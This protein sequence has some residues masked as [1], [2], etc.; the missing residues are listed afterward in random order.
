MLTREQ[1]D[2][3]SFLSGANA[4]FIAELYAQYLD[5]PNSVD[6]SWV[7]FFQDIKDNKPN[8][9]G[10]LKGASWSPNKTKI[11]TQD[12]MAVPKP[13]NTAAF[14]TTRQE[15]VDSIR[16]LMMIRVYRVRGHLEA[17]LDPLGLMERNKY[18]EL[19]P[20]SYGFSDAD[21]DRPI[22]IDGVLGFETA[23]LREIYD[24]CRATY[25]GSIGVEFMHIQDPAQKA[26]IQTAM[27][28][29]RN[30]T[31]FTADEK[32]V[33]LQELSEAEGF[34]KFLHTKFQGTKRFGLDGGEATI[35]MMDEIIKKS[36]SFG[37]REVIFGMAHR[38][39]LNVL[40]NVL[41]KPFIN[42]MAEFKGKPMNPEDIE[43][44]GD[45]KYHL[46]SSFDRDFDG[47]TCHL[48]LTP[49][50]SH[51]ESVN[52][53]AIGK[54]R[55]KQD[56]RG[57]KNRE[58]VLGII[59]HGDA[60]IAGQGLTAET[61][62][63]SQLDG[64]KTGGTI[65]IVINNQ[66]GFTTS[67]VDSRSSPYCSDVAKMVQAPIF[68]VNGDDVEAVVHVA[69]LAAEFRHQ[70][71][72][73][74]VIDM[75]CYR[76]YGHNES[77][78]PMFT[79]PLMYKAI[80][81][82]TPTREIYVQKLIDEGVISLADADA[83]YDNF[84]RDLEDSLNA[85]EKYKPNKADWLEGTW[86]GLKSGMGQAE[87]LGS[88]ALTDKALREVMQAITTTPNGFDT[89]KKVERQLNDKQEMMKSGNGIDWATAEALAFGSL[90]AE[91]HTVRLSGQDCGR[92]T[93]S[94]RH[95]VLRDQTTGEKFVPL[96]TLGKNNAFFEVIDSPLA[97]ASVLGFDYGY[98]SASPM[99][100]VLWEAQFGDFANGAQVIIDQY[101][102]SAE[103]KWLRMSGLVMLL[104]H[105]YE[106]QG[107]EH[108]SARLERFLQLCAEDNLQVANCSTPANYFHILR[109]QVKRDFRKPLIL[110]TPK[111][112][113][114]HKLCVSDMKDFAEGTTFHR[115]LPD[116]TKLAADK[117]VRR[118]VLCSGKVY[119]DLFEAREA[120]KVD[121][122]AIVRI[123]QFYPF[124]HNSLKQAIG[125]YS[126]AD[127]VW[128]QEEPENMGAWTFL[129]RR[130]EGVLKEL[131]L[132]SQRPEYVG[133]KASASPATGYLKRHLAEQENLVKTALGIN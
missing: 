126:N 48:S 27:E 37:I 34:E 54:V 61:F 69:R 33:I 66:I 89:N 72:S 97:E 3:S 105:G 13:A 109:R 47:V 67:P 23:T 17:N 113:L 90:L 43:Y 49:N 42:I 77:D 50:P 129:D 52:P 21:W 1:F 65:H 125:N 128:C 73:D 53:V 104:P 79:Q 10:E 122:V 32:K 46:G 92:G 25:C 118:V 15:T 74:I 119:Y 111:S 45:V 94:Q 24:T 57:D 5:N 86:K 101:I 82:R 44:S 131:Q 30:K 63:L 120:A 51:L 107:P 6:A 116:T 60:A 29:N 127:V 35:P 14:T 71:K 106:G 59:L 91:G 93:F 84:K 123:E 11:I 96:S 68:H 7:Q 8:L 115:V 36:V 121:D 99:A 22:F 62:L 41:Q 85:A 70:F 12:K 117:K 81:K 31:Y 103:S 64:Y 102:A 16:A 19:D 39:R 76:R 130:I 100:L 88:T 87:N 110:M 95:A 56:L 4:H 78:E 18:S 38:G 98:S 83:V 55:A 2:E 112:L 133:R 108:S 114:R 132:K 26:F 75:F 20:M 80:S 40:A 58:T 9:A 28:E 124:P